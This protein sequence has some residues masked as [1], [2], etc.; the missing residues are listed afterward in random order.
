MPP[1]ILVVADHPNLGQL[2]ER[3]L[4]RD[5]FIVSTARTGSDLACAFAFQPPDL[6]LTDLDMEQVDPRAVIACTRT[7][8]PEIA[9]LVMTSWLDD[10]HDAGVHVLP[11][12]FALTT[13]LDRVRQA[14]AAP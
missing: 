7:H 10:M 2:V 11:K 6:L 14:L 13:L 9:L 4:R 5:G 1:Q 3:V 8:C 12:P